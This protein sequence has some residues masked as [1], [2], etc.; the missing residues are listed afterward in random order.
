MKKLLL[1]LYF[2]LIGM[3]WGWTV[4]VDFYV[5]PSVFANIK[6]FFEAGNLGITVFSKLNK[7]EL[8][9]GTV[10]TFLIIRTIGLNKKI[11]KFIIPALLATII[12][13][14]YES[15]LTAKIQE[16][17][18]LWQMAEAKNTVGIQGIPDIQ[19]EHQYYHKLYVTLDSVKLLLLTVMLG[20]GIWKQK[21]L[22]CEN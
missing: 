19:Q 5:I 11:L 1:P 14:F 12:A 18:I 10:L 2:I 6:G 17:T 3:W 8:I 20:L 13:Y 16:L 22:A 21:D 4:L 15:Y 9:V 7:L